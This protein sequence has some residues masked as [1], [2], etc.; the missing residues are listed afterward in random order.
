MRLRRKF[1][2]SIDKMSL[3][4]HNF[5]LTQ[6]TKSIKVIIIKFKLPKGEIETVIT[7]LFDYS[8]GQKAFKEL[9]FRR[10]PIET[11]YSKVKHKLEI[12]NFSSRTEESIYQDYYITIFVHNLISISS[13]KAQYIC[14]DARKHKKNKYKYKINFNNAVGV[15]KNRFVLVLITEYAAQRH[16]IINEII[17][18]MTKKVIPIRPNR[19]I[20]RNKTPRKANF[21]HNQKSNC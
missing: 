7:N 19:S 15:F 2:T 9:Y 6:D 20:K 12:E 3:G 10:W 11:L 14:D 16:D 21:H 1:N 4:C 8:L 17:T 5:I 13:K 18:N